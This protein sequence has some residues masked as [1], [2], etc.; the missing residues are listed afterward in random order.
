[1]R[2]LLV[3]NRYR[4]AQPSGENV[5]V[6]T[7]ARLLAENGCEVRR[8]ESES[9]EIA[10]WPL[11][12]KVTLPIRVVWSREGS[13]Q[14]HD[15]I[16]RF[17]P[18]VVH[19]HNTFPL[20]SPAA[21]WAAR[22]SGVRVIQTLRNFRPLCAS[23][24][25]LRKQRVCEECL[26]RNPVPAVIHGCYRDSRLASVPVA[27]MNAL[28]HFIGTWLKCV[29]V[30]ITPS[31]FARSKYVE[32]GW[33]PE[34]LVVKYNTVAGTPLPRHAD[35]KGFVCVS[36]LSDEKGVDVLL[37]AWTRA[38]PDGGEGLQL[39]GSGDSEARL[40]IAAA[41][42]PGVSFRGQLP[43]TDVRQLLAR[44]R[45]AVVPS[46]CY[47]TFS[48]VVG[49]AFSLGTPVI[50]SR[51]GALAEIVN[52]GEN[53]LLIKPGDPRDIARGLTQI[54]TSD[55][56]THTLGRCARGDFEKKFDP[57]VT[58][59]RLLSIYEAP[60]PAAGIVPP[61]TQPKQAMGPLR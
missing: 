1:M 41:G 28:H 51:I 24:D 60:L 22:Q 40:R 6:D 32:A 30:L 16:C 37:E 49:E 58:T 44:C 34:K 12:K 38:F 46:L 17:R 7:E 14:V 33:P 9:D 23:G 48:R 42:A 57:A 31:E 43:Q 26:G 61:T 20:F 5:S 4:A 25:L 27:A 19:L 2:V 21:L 59:A 8:L 35:P 36:R 52:D 54:A 39:V 10:S 47:E 13:Q 29:D 15:A 11:H 56:L 53:G 55:E 45:A 3:H 18:D 50:A